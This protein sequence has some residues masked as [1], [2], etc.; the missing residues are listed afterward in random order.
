M[1]TI[2]EI[3]ASYRTDA[4]KTIAQVAHDLN[5]YE[6]NLVALEA[7][8]YDNLPKGVYARHL[9]KKY[10]EY[11]GL[12]TQKV[13]SQFDSEYTT[14]QQL[15]PQHTKDD[16][17]I[18]TPKLIKKLI[19]AGISLLVVAYFAFQIYFIFQPPTL[20]I[21]KPTE[22]TILTESYIEVQGKT[23]PEAIVEINDKQITIDDSG[24]FSTT[25]DLSTGINII[26]ISA[27]KKN[28]KPNI[29]Y[30][31]ILVQPQQ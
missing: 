11:L 1:A 20:I 22:N 21:T 2:G 27:K 10:A 8:N 14:D 31:E 25:I 6:K 24:L 4:H 17:I 18:F 16:G 9:V 19:I 12:D 13:L 7:G 29:I 26:S 15:T 23:E 28:S 5:V 30:R 3:L